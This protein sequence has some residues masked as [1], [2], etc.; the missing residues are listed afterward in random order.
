MTGA[1][2]AVGTSLALGIVSTRPSDYAYWRAWASRAFVLGGVALLVVYGLAGL[3]GWAVFRGAGVASASHPDVLSILEGLAGH[4]ALRAQFERTA[5]GRGGEGGRSLLSLSQGWILEWLHGVSRRHVREHLSG[6]TDQ[7]LVDL[8][9][10]IFWENVDPVR[11]DDAVTATHHEL[12][13]EAADQLNAGANDRAD[14][15]G[16]LRG[17]C[18]QEIDRHRLT[19][20]SGDE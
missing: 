3:A 13:R 7:A 9:F 19:P 1:L 17:F 16:R 15:H 2:I 10:D 18:L 14:A 5:L 8:S 4:G 6:L 11:T 12:L 20:W